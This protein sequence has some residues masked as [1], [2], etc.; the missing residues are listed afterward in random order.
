MLRSSTATLA[1]VLLTAPAALADCSFYTATAVVDNDVIL[2]FAAGEGDLTAAPLPEHPNLFTY[3]SPYVGTLSCTDGS[4]GTGLAGRS[5]TCVDDT[6]EIALTNTARYVV[7]FG[8]EAAMVFDNHIFHAGCPAAFPE[9]EGT[10]FELVCTPEWPNSD[11]GP[12]TMSGVIGQRIGHFEYETA[13]LSGSVEFRPVGQS[14]VV[15]SIEHGYIV[16]AFDNQTLTGWT[17]YEHGADVSA[18]CELM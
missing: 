9:E 15:T 16:M 8:E 6:G 12:I 2:Q 3:T 14:T 17:P 10:E 13:D 18:Q 4:M 5:V 7:P 1:F 11:G